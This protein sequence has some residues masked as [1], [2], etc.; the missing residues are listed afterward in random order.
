[1]PPAPARPT[2][3][4]AGSRSRC[5][6]S[7]VRTFE[8]FPTPYAEPQRPYP[9]DEQANRGRAEAPAA[10]AAQPR[11]DA[12]EASPRVESEGKSQSYPGTGW[13]DRAHDPVVLVSFDPENEPCQRTTLR[14]EYRS[15]LVALGILPPRFVPRDRLWQRE[16]AEPGFAQP[17]RW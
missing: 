10:S 1:M 13:G 7:G 16:H 11:A 9:T 15:T 14:Y 3:R 6:A 2:R 8:R 17:P 12:G 5:T 4:W